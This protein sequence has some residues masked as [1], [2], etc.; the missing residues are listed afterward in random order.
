MDRTVA[1][2]RRL[3]NALYIVALTDVASKPVNFAVCIAN[4]SH[5]A[6]EFILAPRTDKY[7]GPFPRVRGRDCFPDAAAAARHQSNSA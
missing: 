3:Y 1:L 7:A 6:V 4:I 2:C 5:G